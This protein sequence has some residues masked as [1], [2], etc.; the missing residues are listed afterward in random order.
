[1]STSRDTG[2]GTIKKFYPQN[3]AI[4]VGIWFVFFLKLDVCLEGGGG[5][6]PPAA[7]KRHRKTVAG[8]RVN[9]THSIS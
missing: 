1:M 9:L 5:K 8:T 4:A 7:G 6:I 2:S 3:T